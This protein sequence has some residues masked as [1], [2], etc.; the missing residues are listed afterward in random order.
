V[1]G[2]AEGKLT[3]IPSY[4]YEIESMPLKEVKIS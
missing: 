2:G 4:M 3:I 1:N